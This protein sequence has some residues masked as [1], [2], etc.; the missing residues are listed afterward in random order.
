[1]IKYETITRTS[2]LNEYVEKGWKMIHCF[3]KVT[4]HDEEGRAAQYQPAFVIVWEIPGE[5]Q[6]PED[7]SQGPAEPLGEIAP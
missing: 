6:Y 2:K 1:M 4:E 5:P 3:T 7:R